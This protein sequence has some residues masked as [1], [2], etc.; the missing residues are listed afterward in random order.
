MAETRRSIVTKEQKDNLAYFCSAYKMLGPLHLSLVP[1][2]YHYLTFCLPVYSI[3][4]T[5]FSTVAQL[6]LV[7]S[8][9][10]FI[11]IGKF[12]F[13]YESSRTG[14]MCNLGAYADCRSSIFQQPLSIT[15]SGKYYLHFLNSNI[16][17]YKNSAESPFLCLKSCI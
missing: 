5:L 10:G 12:K 7:G 17:F 16:S 2:I 3:I 11:L 14:P 6:R 15:S 9:R 8:I 13:M 4:S 1:G